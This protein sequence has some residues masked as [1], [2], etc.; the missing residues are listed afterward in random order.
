MAEKSRGDR[1]DRA[2]SLW[3]EGTPEASWPHLALS[4]QLTA[5]SLLW[6]RLSGPLGPA[7]LHLVTKDVIIYLIMF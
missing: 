7:L 4:I 5:V 3:P 6:L 1:L 2:I